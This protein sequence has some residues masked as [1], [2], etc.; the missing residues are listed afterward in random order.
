MK[1][2]V[3]LLESD[4]PARAIGKSL[5]V[6]FLAGTVKKGGY[7]KHHFSRRIKIGGYLVPVNSICKS[8]HISFFQE[9]VFIGY[10][11]RCKQ[12]LVF[13][14]GPTAEMLHNFQSDR[15]R[16]VCVL[17]KLMEGLFIHVSSRGRDNIDGL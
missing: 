6:F 15:R 9:K 13:G 3:Q 1:K 4:K 14:N 17:K 16:E 8:P 5:Y 7:L 12:E 2:V 11:T 10:F